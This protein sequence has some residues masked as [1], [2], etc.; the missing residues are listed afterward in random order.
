MDTQRDRLSLASEAVAEA[1]VAG[2]VRHHERI[3]AALVPELVLK[4][5]R[6][7]VRDG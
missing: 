4:G 6:T 3:E 1:P 5:L 7:G 2:A